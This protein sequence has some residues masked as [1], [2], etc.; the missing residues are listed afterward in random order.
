MLSDAEPPR[1]WPTRGIRAMYIC[2]KAPE[3]VSRVLLRLQNTSSLL[4]GCRKLGRKIPPVL[5]IC[6]LAVYPTLSGLNETWINK[7]FKD[8]T[9]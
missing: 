2:I 9:H 7:F 5:Y 1:G 3:D 4:R 6:V 8:E